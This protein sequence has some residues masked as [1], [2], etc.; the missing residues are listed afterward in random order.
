M[1]SYI[2]FNLFF[3]NFHCLLFT[4]RSLDHILIMRTWFMVRLTIK[5]HRKLE[6]IQYSTCLAIVGTFYQKLNQELG[7]KTLISVWW[8]RKLCLSYRIV[9]NQSHSYLFDCIPSTDRIDKRIYSTSHVAIV[10]TRKSGHTLFKDSYIP[11]T[12]REWYRLNQDIRNTE[13]YTLFK[14]H[15]LSF[16]RSEVYITQRG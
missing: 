11:T 15:L 5:F 7:L 13:S 8:C 6:S 4:K 10:S 9:S 14:K 16:I 1:V 12:I 3:Q 2:D